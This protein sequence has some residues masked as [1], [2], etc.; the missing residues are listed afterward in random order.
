MI[1]HEPDG[2][3]GQVS[4]RLRQRGFEVVTHVVTPDVAAPNEA[5]PFPDFAAF[6]LVA[7]MG[8][9]RSLTRKDEIDSWVHD[10]L[11]R[12]RDAA[13]RDQPIL[14]VCF[15][16][17]LIADAL[18][19]AV[20]ESPEVEVGWRSITPA[21]GVDNPVGPGPWMEWHHDRFTP[22]PGAELLA[23]TPVGPQLFTLG[24]MVGTQFHPEIDHEHVSVWLGGADAEYLDGVGVDPEALLAEIA[25]HDDRNTEQCHALVDW[26]LERSGLAEHPRE[27]PV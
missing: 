19:G 24:R 15:G 11:D 5:T 18:G 21:P 16:G 13:E 14:G 26:F 6:E 25:A 1:A 4:V 27:E 17:Q 20:E 2:P 22:P 9:I 8:S 7:I 12:I 3:G 23:T 10:E